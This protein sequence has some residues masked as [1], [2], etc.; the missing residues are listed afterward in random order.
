MQRIAAPALDAA[1]CDATNCNTASES[2]ATPA[3]K[4]A[5]FIRHCLGLFDDP[6]TTQPRKKGGIICRAIKTTAARESGPVC[7]AATRKRAAQRLYVQANS[8]R[9]Q[10]SATRNHSRRCIP[11][12]IK[13]APV[14]GLATRQRSATRHDVN[15]VATDPCNL[16]HAVPGKLCKYAQNRAVQALQNRPISTPRNTLQELQ[17]AISNG[18]VVFRSTPGSAAQGYP[19]RPP[20]IDH[21]RLYA[22]GVEFS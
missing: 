19:D 16:A 13:A 17:A 1:S 21:L 3:N 5:P 10:P 2:Q 4:A 12:A 15:R 8:A 11:H 9:G 14:E 18:L 20:G 6:L 22:V 7:Y